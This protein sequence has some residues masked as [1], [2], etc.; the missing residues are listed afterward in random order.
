MSI[1]AQLLASFERIVAS[2]GGTLALLA[3]SDEA[4]RMGYRGAAEADCE[5]GVCLLPHAEIEAMMRDWLARK[6]PALRLEVV[7][8]D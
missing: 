4:I 1:A 8:I 2:D 5:N 6:A 7:P 3:E